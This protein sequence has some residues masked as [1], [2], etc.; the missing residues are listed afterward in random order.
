M[1]NGRGLKGYKDPRGHSMR[2][3]DDVF[4]SPAFRA[5]SPHDVLAYLALLRELRATNNGDLSLPLT[6]SKRYGIG[7]HVTLARSLRALCAVGIIAITRKG[8]CRKGGEKLPTLY[9]VT[10]VEAYEIPAKGLEYCKATNEWKKVTSLEHGQQLIA[11]HEERAK[12]G[13]SKINAGHGV[14]TTMSRGDVVE[15][16]TRTRG[17]STPIQPCHAVSLAKTGANPIS[18]RVSEGFS[19]PIEKQS[20][21]TR[22]RPPL[23]TATPTGNFLPPDEHGNYKRLTARPSNQFT[24]LM[25]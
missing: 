5:L 13:V 10:D 12:G 7:H 21:R 20:P 6:R 25:H 2:I 19:R 11:E 24:N 1:A 9:R 18:M 8:G 16:K 3:Y 4:D 22:D 17:D 15:P 23:H 14:T